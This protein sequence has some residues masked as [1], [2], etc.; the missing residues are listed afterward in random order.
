MYINMFVY[1]Y[2]CICIYTEREKERKREREMLFFYLSPQIHFKI[3]FCTSEIHRN[4]R[5]MGDGLTVCLL[6]CQCVYLF[7]CLSAW[8]ACMCVQG[9]CFL[10][11][12]ALRG[13]HR[14]GPVGGGRVLIAAGADVVTNGW[15]TD[16]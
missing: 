6:D 11:R 5:I 1:I 16:D 7:V 9:A 8:L 2:I 4:S 14:C 12:G 3:C 13:Y 15:W 10:V